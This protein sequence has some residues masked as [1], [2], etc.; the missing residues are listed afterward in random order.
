GSRTGIP[1]C[2]GMTRGKDKHPGPEPHQSPRGFHVLTEAAISTLPSRGKCS[3]RTAGTI[4]PPHRASLGLA[5]GPLST[6]KKLGFRGSQAGPRVEP[7]A[8][9]LNFLDYVHDIDS[10]SF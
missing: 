7:T 3:F 9:R 8:V 10:T 1:A 4:Y 5:R 2:G 6:C